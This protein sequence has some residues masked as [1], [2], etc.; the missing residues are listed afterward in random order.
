MNHFDHACEMQEQLT[1]EYQELMARQKEQRAQLA[2]AIEHAFAP[3]VTAAEHAQTPGAIKATHYRMSACL[4]GD[5]WA[6][7]PNQYRQ[8][9][10]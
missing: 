5:W 9:I 1:R 10:A 2:A 4:I 8:R 3:A 6:V 7:A